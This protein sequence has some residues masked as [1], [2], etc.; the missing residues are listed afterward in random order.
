MNAC[1]EKSNTKVHR[2]AIDRMGQGLNDKHCNDANEASALKK[3]PVCG[4]FHKT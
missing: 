1:L 4:Y 2:N 3:P